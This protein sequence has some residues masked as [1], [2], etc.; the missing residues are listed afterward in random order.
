M[1]RRVVGQAVVAGLVGAVA[2]LGVRVVELGPPE[3]ARRALFA[4]DQRWWRLYRRALVAL[5][6]DAGALDKDPPDPT[7]VERALTDLITSL[8]A[9]AA[10]RTQKEG[11]MHRESDFTDP[12][13]RRLGALALITDEFGDVLLVEKAYKSGPERFG[14][15]GGCARPGEPL[16]TACARE[17][18]EET[19]LD[20]MPQRVLAV[21]QMPASGTA[22]EGVNLVFDGGLVP[23]ETALTLPPDELS[24][25]QWCPVADLPDVVAPYMLWRITA[26]LSALHGDPVRHL[27]GGPGELGRP[28]EKAS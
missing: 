8:T 2:G 19:G 22:T 18:R 7:H 25:Y 24:G 13:P 10:S 15:P 27:H 3:A 23:R 4:V 12:S 9:E 21:H 20:I 5:G 14:L 1:G 28:A 26:A 16:P 11:H 6:E 17:V